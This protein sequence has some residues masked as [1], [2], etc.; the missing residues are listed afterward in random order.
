MLHSHGK[1]IAKH[2]VMSM[3]ESGVLLCFLI[4]YYGIADFAKC[5]AF[6]A[7]AMTSLFPPGCRAG[8]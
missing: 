1:V 8:R 3:V 5:V 4:S 6:L 2:N 7:T